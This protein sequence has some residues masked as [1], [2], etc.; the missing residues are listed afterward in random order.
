MSKK[1]LLLDSDS[2]VYQILKDRLNRNNYIL[3][4]CSNCKDAREILKNEHFD[5]LI[6]DILLPDMD[7][8]TFCLNIR[9][10]SYIPIILLTTL[11][12]IKDRLLGFKIGADDYITKPFY[13]NE[14]E[15]RIKSLLNRVELSNSRCLI[16]EDILYI[17][18]LNVNF[19]RKKVSKEGKDINLT[20]LEFKILELLIIEAGKALSRNF[21]LQSIWGYVPERYSDVRIIDVHI[22]RL[23]A[24][25]EENPNN[26]DFIITNWGKGYMFEKFQK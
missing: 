3:F 26:P 22:F 11:D 21:I 13:L 9:K 4:F 25:I 20:K 15:A 8:Y 19:I 14:F 12:N 18:N 6:L 2:N 23:R 1:I 10:K 17:G 5:L 16:N 7:G 24:K